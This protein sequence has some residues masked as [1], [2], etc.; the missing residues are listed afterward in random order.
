MFFS[1]SGGI[2]LALNDS[3]F[4]MFFSACK[5]RLRA[6]IYAASGYLS[7]VSLRLRVGC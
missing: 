6:A 4:F 1:G 7:L 5:A 3:Q 2:L